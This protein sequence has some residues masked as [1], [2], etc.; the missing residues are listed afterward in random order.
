MVVFVYLESINTLTLSF[1]PS[2]VLI[3]GCTIS[4]LDCSLL[5]GITYRFLVELFTVVHCIMPTLNL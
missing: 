1:L 3:I 5:C 2:F 4:S